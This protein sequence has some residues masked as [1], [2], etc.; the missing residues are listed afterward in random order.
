MKYRFVWLLLAVLLLAGCTAPTAEPVPTPTEPMPEPIAE[1]EPVTESEVVVESE[2]NVPQP[3]APVYIYRSE[4]HQ[5]AV[6]PTGEVLLD[7]DTG[8]LNLLYNEQGEPCYIVRSCTEGA[9]EELWRSWV[10]LYDLQGGSCRNC[11]FINIM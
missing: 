8:V 5:V 6:S 7:V 11:H 10:E 1:P 4:S 2:A 3:T 9:T